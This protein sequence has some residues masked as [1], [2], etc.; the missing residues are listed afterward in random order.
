MVDGIDIDFVNR[1]TLKGFI[2][3][4]QQEDTLVYA[5]RINLTVRRLGIRN[6][7]FR[8]GDLEL[9]NAMVNIRKIDEKGGTNFDFI[10]D[11]FSNPDTLSIDSVRSNLLL[12]AQS[13]V[14][15]NCNF[16]YRNP[17][18]AVVD[19]GMDLNNVSVNSIH[20]SI[21]NFLFINDSLVCD[22]QSFSFREKS[23]LSLQNLKGQFRLNDEGLH[24]H[25]LELATTNS[26][27]RGDIALEHNAW[28][29][30]SDFLHAVKWNGQLNRSKINLKDIGYFVPELYHVDL[31]FYVEC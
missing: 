19:S 11:Y 3:F 16:S 27:I 2:V 4:D 23:G 8:F 18:E 12:S 22:F 17:F 5:K 25:N 10:T 21:E 15:T 13:V 7:T 1:L 30:Y 31:P 28:I 14:L 24:T 20:G 6:N 26:A 9:D 29:D